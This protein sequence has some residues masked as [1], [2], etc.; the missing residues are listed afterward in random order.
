[1]KCLA[2]LRRPDHS[3]ESHQ[4]RPTEVDC[5]LSS[6]LHE[7]LKLFGDAVVPSDGEQL[8]W[9]ESSFVDHLEWLRRMFPINRGTQDVMTLNYLVC[10]IDP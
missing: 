2:A 5:R 6:W 10:R 4:W 8:H 1:M 3:N 9:Q 7:L